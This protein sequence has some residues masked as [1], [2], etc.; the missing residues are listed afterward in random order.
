MPS[1]SRQAGNEDETV[2]LTRDQ[3]ISAVVTEIEETFY[4][5]ELQELLR[6]EAHSLAAFAFHRGVRL[7]ASDQAARSC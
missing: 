2:T 7:S 4:G 6:L 1:E 5:T 3:F